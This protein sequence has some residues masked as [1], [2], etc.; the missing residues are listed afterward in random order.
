MPVCGADTNP[1][2]V[3]EGKLVT[4][5]ES[6]P[7]STAAFVVYRKQLKQWQQRT[8]DLNR[9]REKHTGNS[10]DP[11]ELGYLWLLYLLFEL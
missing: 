7:K 6:K 5:Q 10:L 2:P 4:V 8:T 11:P 9:A 3:V 1:T